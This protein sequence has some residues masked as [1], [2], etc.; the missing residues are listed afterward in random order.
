MCYCSSA[1]YNKMRVIHFLGCCIFNCSQTY[2]PIRIS[3]FS[4]LAMRTSILRISV[5]N[6][7]CFYCA[8]VAF[9]VNPRNPRIR[10]SKYLS[11]L[12]KKNAAFSPPQALRFNSTAVSPVILKA[13]FFFFFLPLPGFQKCCRG[14]GADVS[15]H[16][17]N[18]CEY[19]AT[20]LLQAWKK[21]LKSVAEGGRS[22]AERL[23]DFLH[24][25]KCDFVT[26]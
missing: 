24:S 2:F 4:F 6:F 7:Q 18:A 21:L 10:F 8:S 12:K 20:E 16:S 17:W 26:R 25:Q 15:P 14:R 3:R 1:K 9:F 19:I 13:R 22:T 11:L 5:L 23:K